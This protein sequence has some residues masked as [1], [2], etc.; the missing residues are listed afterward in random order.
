MLSN[1][2]VF[3]GSGTFGEIY[4]SNVYRTRAIKAIKLEKY[5]KRSESEI[6]KQRNVYNAFNKYKKLTS[7]FLISKPGIF[8]YLK[9]NSRFKCFYDMERLYNP[10]NRAGPI[11]HL[12]FN[13]EYNKISKVKEYYSI[14]KFKNKFGIQKLENI[15]HLMG[16][17]FAIVVIEARLD[18]SD[19]EFLLVRGKDQNPKL[20]IIDFGVCKSINI[21]DIEKSV[22]QIITECFE[23]HNWYIP[24]KGKNLT[25]YAFSFL[26][27]FMEMG[28]KI[29]RG[30]RNI[31]KFIDYLYLT[32]LKRIKYFILVEILTNLFTNMPFKTYLDNVKTRSDIFDYIWTFNNNFINKLQNQLKK[33]NIFNKQVL[34]LLLKNN[35]SIQDV[36]NQ[37]ISKYFVKSGKKA[38][39]I[40][41]DNLRIYIYK[42]IMEKL[43]MIGNLENFYNNI[44]EILRKS[45]KNYS[46][47]ENVCFG[48][49]H[50]TQ[51]PTPTKVRREMEKLDFGFSK[52]PHDQKGLI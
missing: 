47:I 26:Y 38:F 24:Y 14:Q 18:A 45:R 50:E 12:S 51:S 46:F 4:G 52:S 49:D 20:S 40:Y 41:H 22:N 32:V 7:N 42:I 1:Y 25:G 33:N 17:G 5:C 30:D 27:G 16:N 8:K 15:L 43:K 19:I 6:I 28:H 48:I 13:T 11:I 3:L 44:I 34:V 2:N 9:N 10:W 29:S 37:S 39:K 36:N 31:I 35:Y 21:F 23:F